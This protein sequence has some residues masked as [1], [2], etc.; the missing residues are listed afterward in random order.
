MKNDDIKKLWFGGP[1]FL[2]LYH[3]D[4][5]ST[6]YFENYK[7]NESHYLA[8]LSNSNFDTDMKNIF[9]LEK[10]NSF[11][12]LIRITSFVSRFIDNMKLKVE[13]KTVVSKL[14]VDEINRVRCLL[15]K[16]KQK[17]FLSSN[18]IKKELAN[19]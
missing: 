7:S 16:N 6:K 19:N 4:W 1:P 11:D 10:Y 8:E 13:N 14:N 9:S 2:E 5:P 3:E 18:E 15:I 12:K 17:D